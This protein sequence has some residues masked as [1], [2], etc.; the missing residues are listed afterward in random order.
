MSALSTSLL[1]INH[2]TSASPLAN[3]LPAAAFGRGRVG[4]VGR[5]T[6]PLPLVPRSS[7][8]LCGGLLLRQRGRPVGRPR[9]PKNARPPPSI[10]TKTNVVATANRSG[11]SVGACGACDAQ[12]ANRSLMCVSRL[13][14][15]LRERTAFGGSVRPLPP[16]RF[17]H[18]HCGCYGSR[19]VLARRQVPVGLLLCAYRRDFRCSRRDANRN[20]CLVSG[21]GWALEKCKKTT[22]RKA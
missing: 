7:V 16:R 19:N 3:A 15:R 8:F 13:V 12:C 14:G 4:C 11:F 1:L 17:N 9:P 10:G 6:R 18:R 20:K 5:E 2:F 21:W 22:N